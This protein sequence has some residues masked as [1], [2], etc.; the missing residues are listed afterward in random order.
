MTGIAADLMFSEAQNTNATGPQ[1]PNESA[2]VQLLLADSWNAPLWKRLLAEFRDTISPEKLPP[3]QLT[4]RP[5]DVGMLQ[6]DRLSLPWY[7]TV[8]TNVGDVI[9]PEN[10]PPLELESRPVDV[11][12]LIADQMARPWWSSLVR[13]LA[14][15]LAPERMPP[16]DLTS[17]PMDPGGTTDSMSL[18]RWSSVID[19]PKV[20]LPDKPKQE[21]V[22]VLPKPVVSKPKPDAAE[23]QYVH[24]IEADLKRDLRRSILRQRLWITLAALEILAL[25]GSSLFWK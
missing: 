21:Y 10:L 17:K 24:A 2:D 13:N 19:T 25:V 8:F 5:V 3:L 7:R 11:G 15:K 23:L 4:S 6:G 1:P 12:E 22:L 20:F 16:L 18:P 9:T 14:D